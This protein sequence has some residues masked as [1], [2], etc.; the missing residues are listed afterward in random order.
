MTNLE[1]SGSSMISTNLIGE[2]N[3]YLIQAQIYLLL[4]SILKFEKIINS[5]TLC[6]LYGCGR[7]VFLCLLYVFVIEKE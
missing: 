6:T 4:V 2:S 3:L 1:M 7:P 5:V